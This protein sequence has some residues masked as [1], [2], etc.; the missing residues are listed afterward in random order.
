MRQFTEDEIDK[1]CCMQ[2]QINLMKDE[3]SVVE[4]MIPKQTDQ[5]YG[6]MMDVY[7]S[8]CK[9]I[10]RME[11]EIQTLIVQVAQI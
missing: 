2:E 8:M 3:L 10:K 6:G 7:L 4:D 1:I 5:F 9:D 11:E